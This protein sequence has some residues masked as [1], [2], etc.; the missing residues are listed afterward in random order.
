LFFFPTCVSLSLSLL[1]LLY[2]Y[3]E[4][5][6]RKKAR[7]MNER[8]RKEVVPLGHTRGKK[9]QDGS[10]KKRCFIYPFIL[11][12]SL[13]FNPRGYPPISL[14]LSLRL[15]VENHRCST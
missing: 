4:E 6:T 10:K 9:K 13:S 14:F 2:S 12:L 15:F 11:S 8:E 7:K 5:K 1:M 3:D